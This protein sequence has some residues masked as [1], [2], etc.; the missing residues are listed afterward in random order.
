MVRRD[1]R[2]GRGASECI[3]AA[4][5]LNAVPRR[6]SEEWRAPSR[7]PFSTGAPSGNARRRELM[8][9]FL[10]RAR[11]AVCVVSFAA[12]LGSGLACKSGPDDATLAANV[13]AKVT[14]A[15]G[16]SSTVDVA[17][18]SGVVTL[19]GTVASDSAKAQTQEVAQAVEGV[20][21]VRNQLT[22]APPAPAVDNSQDLAL[23]NA[24][25]ANLSKYGVSGV[26]ADARAGVVTLTGSV[27]RD[28]L[29][30]AM[31][32]ANEASPRPT[33]VDNQL[34]IR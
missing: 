6:T 33:R 15:A 13:K 30:K 18:K 10:T 7:T 31:Q 24:V 25:A 3:S 29:V 19:T 26:S 11:Q 12:C 32:A 9:T 23:R 27:T 22:I 16:P 1:V 5:R 34:V 17:A 4:S 14:S 21:E 20:K 8:M 2:D 28:Q